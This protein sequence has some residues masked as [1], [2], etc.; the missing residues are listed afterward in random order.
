MN[1]E[2][3]CLS[4]NRQQMNVTSSMFNVILDVV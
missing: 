2:N 1:T 4:N 3:A